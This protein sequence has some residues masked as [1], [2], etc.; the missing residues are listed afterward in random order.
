MR[1]PSQKNK[2]SKKEKIK[3]ERA[4]SKCPMLQ[5]SPYIYREKKRVK[6][7]D[8]NCT[9]TYFDLAQ[10]FVTQSLISSQINEIFKKMD[11]FLQI[12]LLNLTTLHKHK[13]KG[14][15][16]ETT[17]QITLH[18]EKKSAEIK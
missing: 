2:K 1:V 10:E 18:R 5:E 7:I 4:I 9:S 6:C 17:L 15:K 13:K 3:L 12:N 14:G 8:S 11:I 16:R